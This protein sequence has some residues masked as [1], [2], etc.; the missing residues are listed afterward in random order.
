M[1]RD[2][3]KN[4]FY[5][6]WVTEFSMIII[7]QS[8]PFFAFPFNLSRK[9]S[10]LAFYAFCTSNTS[11]KKQKQDIHIYFV[12]SYYMALGTTLLLPCHVQFPVQY[13][14]SPIVK[15]KPDCIPFWTVWTANMEQVLTTTKNLLYYLTTTMRCT[16][17]HLLLLLSF[18]FYNITR[19]SFYKERRMNVWFALLCCR[20]WW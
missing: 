18:V 5:T 14:A 3:R 11:K 7:P 19:F 10:A 6:T 15:R 8:Y 1:E 12:C 9:K 17:K 2:T 16:Q 20:R 4:L 13:P